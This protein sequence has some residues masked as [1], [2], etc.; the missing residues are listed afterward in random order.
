MEAAKSGKQIELERRLHFRYQSS[1]VAERCARL[2][3]GLLR[4]SGGNGIYNTNPLVR[5]FLD[6]HAAR[7]H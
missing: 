1:Q 4:Y 5:R 6:L 3:N 2:A 7:G